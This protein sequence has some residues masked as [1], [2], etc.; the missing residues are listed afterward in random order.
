MVTAIGMFSAGGPDR[1]EM[2][3][4]RRP[5][6]VDTGNFMPLAFQRPSTSSA[7]TYTSTSPRPLQNRPVPT[8]RRCGCCR[9]SG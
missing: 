4:V 8:I 7:T 2:K 9:R 5:A 6:E 3:F 1:R